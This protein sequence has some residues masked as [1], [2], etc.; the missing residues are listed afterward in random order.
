M[1]FF[2]QFQIS[3]Y[4]SS[5]TITLQDAETSMKQKIGIDQ[6]DP[7]VDLQCEMRDDITLYGLYKPKMTQTCRSSRLT[8]IELRK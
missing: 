4:E 1:K 8:S 3:T 2:H 5:M 6:G 7:E